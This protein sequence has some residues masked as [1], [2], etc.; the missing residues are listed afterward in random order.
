MLLFQEHQNNQNHFPNLFTH[1]K[2]KCILR[3]SRAHQIGFLTNEQNSVF[4]IHSFFATAF[5][6]AKSI[7]RCKLFC[8]LYLTSRWTSGLSLKTSLSSLSFHRPRKIVSYS[9]LPS[10]SFRVPS[11]PQSQRLQQPRVCWFIGSTPPCSA[12]LSYSARCQLCF[13]HPA[14]PISNSQ[15][16][17]CL[18][19]HCSEIWNLPVFRQL[20][21]TISCFKITSVSTSNSILEKVV[22]ACLPHPSTNNHTKKFVWVVL[23]F[24]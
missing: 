18:F 9:L 24:F 19:R 17:P 3:V 1:W 8:L 5:P 21:F 13:S 4:W 22:W 15:R 16:L 6:E 7:F 23:V 10:V 2:F 12:F 11:L 14:W 20:D